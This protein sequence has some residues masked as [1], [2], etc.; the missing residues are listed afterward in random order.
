MFS[1]FGRALRHSFYRQ[2][3]SFFKADFWF[4]AEELTGFADIGEG[5]LD[6][7]GAGI[8]IHRLAPAESAGGGG[9]AM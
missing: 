9:D 4:V 3:Q 7:A 2:S 5:V 1:D 8:G 6:I